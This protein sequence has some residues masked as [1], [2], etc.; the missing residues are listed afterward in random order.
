MPPGEGYNVQLD[1][2]V[3]IQVEK[4]TNHK[5]ANLDLGLGLGLDLDLKLTVRVKTAIICK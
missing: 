4:T 1:W 3:C 2:H 5:P